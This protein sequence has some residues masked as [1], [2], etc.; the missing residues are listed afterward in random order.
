MRYAC[1]RGNFIDFYATVHV[2]VCVCLYARGYKTHYVSQ[3]QEYVDDVCVNVCAS[4]DPP[5]ESQL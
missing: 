5:E 2:C 4:M 1:S 3:K